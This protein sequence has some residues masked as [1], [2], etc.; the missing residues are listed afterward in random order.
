[1]TRRE[2][3]QLSKDELIALV[4]ETEERFADSNAHAAELIVELETSHK[5]LEQ[6]LSDLVQATKLTNLGRMVSTVCHD[7]GN[8]LASILGYLHILAQ[9]DSA[10]SPVQRKYIQ[11][12]T[13]GGE[14]I[15]R[16]LR[17]LK[18]YLR[19]DDQKGQGQVDLVATAR[20]LIDFL[21]H[22]LE[23]EAVKVVFAPQGQS[24]LLAKLDPT[25]FESVLQNLL[26]NSIDAFNSLKKE[27]GVE[28]E[29]QVTIDLKA[30]KEFLELRYTDNA[31][32]VPQDI[33]T[34]IFDEFFTTKKRGHGT[35]LGLSMIKKQVGILGGEL[36]LEVED[37]I[38]STFIVRL[39]MGL[40]T[41]S[42]ETGGIEKASAAKA[43][44]RNRRRL[45]VV[46][47]EGD[48]VDILTHQLS[49]WFDVEGAS[50][51]GKA[52]EILRK[53]CHDIILVDYTMP[54]DNGLAI[55][56]SLP[57]NWHGLKVLMT[58]NLTPKESV[59]LSES[60]VVDLILIKPLPLPEEMKELI[61]QHFKLK[62]RN[63][64]A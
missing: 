39:P 47:D 12:A 14:R 43:E 26:F 13:Y 1:M 33:R 59:E 58:G 50:D 17:H 49:N 62:R 23:G 54:V 64:A 48:L 38:G 28:I 2:L 20:A 29:R 45:L 35:G 34:K 24:R 40:E 22:K 8:P 51:P 4:E 11:R 27:V 18:C 60:E 6:V 31:G 37:G 5:K 53:G 63:S 61:E 57:Q 30:D 32:G 52:R 16:M 41:K 7:I 36:R 3:E 25:F 42:A 56:Q 9:D 10:L 44:E 19:K 46:D 55:L 21:S 15:N